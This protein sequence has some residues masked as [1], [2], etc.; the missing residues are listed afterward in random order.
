MLFCQNGQPTAPR[1]PIDHSADSVAVRVVCFAEARFDDL[2]RARRLLNREIAPGPTVL[3]LDPLRSPY[4][5][6][7]VD[8]S[9]CSR[10][11]HHRRLAV[12]LAD[13]L[14]SRAA[15]GRCPHVPPRDPCRG[16]AC[17]RHPS[18]P[19][20]PP[21]GNACRSTDG[22]DSSD[23]TDRTSAHTAS[24]RWRQDGRRD[25]I[26]PEPWR[27]GR[28]SHL[29]RRLRHGMAGIGFNW[30]N[31][32]SEPGGPELEPPGLHLL[33]PESIIPAPRPSRHMATR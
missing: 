2:T 21:C 5:T 33:T 10:R 13:G 24:T 16:C 7:L 23:G 15:V 6:D 31:H 22:P 27:T 11:V 19:F 20:W 3:N 28:Q 1:G 32:L 9:R 4:Q 26:D 12:V 8:L 30:A 18:A 17:G 25:R 14:D 29:S